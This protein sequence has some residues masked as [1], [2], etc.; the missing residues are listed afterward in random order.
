MNHGVLSLFMA[1]LNINEQ[2]SKKAT[3]NQSRNPPFVIQHFRNAW[4]NPINFSWLSI[5]PEKGK[6]FS[7]CLSV[8]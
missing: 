1:I 3:P 5:G 4:K 8:H 7:V 2:P 6:K